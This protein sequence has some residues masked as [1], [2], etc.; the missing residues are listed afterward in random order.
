MICRFLSDTEY[1][2]TSSVTNCFLLCRIVLTARHTSHSCSN[3]ICSIKKDKA[4]YTPDAVA[5]SLKK[6]NDPKNFTMVLILTNM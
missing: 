5:P 4:T 3:F 6:N 2:L 1:I